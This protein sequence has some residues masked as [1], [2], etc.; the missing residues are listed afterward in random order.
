MVAGRCSGNAGV[1]Y[2]C[3]VRPLLLIA[4]GI[5]LG[6]CE[7]FAPSNQEATDNSAGPASEEVG[8]SPGMYEVSIIES[9]SGEVTT[10]E[11]LDRQCVDPARAANPE[12]FL[13]EVELAGCT[14]VAP[15]RDGHSIRGELRC[16][17]N[18]NASIIVTFDKGS[19]ERTISGNGPEGSFESHETAHRVG[20]C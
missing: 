4:L 6:A 7:Q 19:W 2:M 8:L 14:S 18:H 12:E 9:V 13:N 17:A 5:S 11:R 1:F 15:V 16:E 3:S 10:T 20:D